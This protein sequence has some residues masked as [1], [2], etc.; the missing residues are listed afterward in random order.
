MKTSEIKKM[1][2]YYLIIILFILSCSKDE[3]VVIDGSKSFISSV[4]LSSLP[5]IEAANTL[6][7]NRNNQVE[8]VLTTFKNNGVNTIRLRLWKSPSNDHSSF[9]EVKIFSQ[10]IKAKGLKVWIS[11]HYS[12]TWADPGNQITPASWQGTSYSTV[13][14]NLYRYTKKIMLELQPDFIQIGNEI[15]GGFLF[16]YGQ[17]H[18]NE[19]NFLDLLATGAKAVRDHSNTTK[20]IMHYAGLDGSS[21]FFN[22][23]NTLDYDI[24]GL[25][26]YPIWHGKNLNQLHATIVNLGGL[27]NKEIII[28]ETA[29][30]FTLQW[31]DFTNNIVGLEEQLILPD[32]PATPLGQKNYLA[33]VKEILMTTNKGIGF[34]YWEGAF[35]SF[36]GPNSTNGSPWE[37]QATYDFENKAL[38]ILNEFNIN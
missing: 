23:L 5:Q 36:Q 15:N 2:L 18:S 4:D 10:R 28:A 33:K 32:Y 13:K 29:Y 25:S 17:I 35:V 16:P 26:Y 1:K 14:E 38:P 22:K 9:E 19:T 27:F 31:N 11:V 20:I 37:N 3:N 12:D 21:W 24:I 8:D 34:C 6:F 30:P 7:Y